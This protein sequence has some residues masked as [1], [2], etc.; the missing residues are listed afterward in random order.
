GGRGPAE[1]HVD[2]RGVEGVRLPHLELVDG[3][4]GNVVAAHQPALVRIPGVGFFGRPALGVGGGD[5][6][7][8]RERKANQKVA[9]KFHHE[10]FPKLQLA[11]AYIEVRPRLLGNE[12]CPHFSVRGGRSSMRARQSPRRRRQA[13][14]I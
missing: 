10:S 7:Q 1:L 9:A 14:C 13:P 6:S 12:E 2:L 3:V 11:Q 5:G 8:Q 4:G